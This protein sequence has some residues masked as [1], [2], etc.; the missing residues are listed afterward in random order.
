M[1]DNAKANVTPTKQ[2]CAFAGAA[3]YRGQKNE[4]FKQ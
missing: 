2:G 1:A 4:Y 3:E